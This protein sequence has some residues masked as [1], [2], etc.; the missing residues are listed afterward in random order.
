LVKTGKV[1]AT[2]LCIGPEGDLHGVSC[3]DAALRLVDAGAKIVGLNCHFDPF[4]TLRAVEQMKTALEKNNIKGIHLMT[5]P[6][7]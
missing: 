5:Q 4:T 2:N 3:G 7:A 6:L 1:T